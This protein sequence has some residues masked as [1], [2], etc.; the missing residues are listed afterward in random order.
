MELQSQGV[1]SKGELMAT[2]IFG[3]ASRTYLR[4]AQ[5]GELVLAAR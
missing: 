5:H 1:K 2:D 3:Y 4:H